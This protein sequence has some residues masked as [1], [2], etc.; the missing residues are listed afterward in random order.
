MAQWKGEASKH[1]KVFQKMVYAHLQNLK[2]SSQAAEGGGGKRVWGEVSR[3]NHE[4]KNGEVESRLGQKF[5]R[6]RYTEVISFH[7]LGSCKELRWAEPCKSSLP[8]CLWK[9]L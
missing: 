8:P 3:K 7:F 9:T 2:D 4:T 5:K 1:L 6:C